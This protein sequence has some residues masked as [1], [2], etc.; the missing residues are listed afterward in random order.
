M[1]F[2][3]IS[4]SFSLRNEDQYNTIGAFWDEMSEIYGLESLIGLGY[5]WDNGKIYYAIG[6]KNRDIPNFN[7]V[8]ELPDDGWKTVSGRTDVLK[9]IYDKIY[10]DGPLSMEIETFFNNGECEVKYI[11]KNKATNL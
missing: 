3:G 9:E 4:R 7:F 6:L 10:K 1:T 2:K 5:K 8:T 11:R